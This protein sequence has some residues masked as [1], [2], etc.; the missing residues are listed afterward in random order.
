LP[1]RSGAGKI[2]A[3]E[4]S[5][6]RFALTLGLLLLSAA[7]VCGQTRGG[8]LRG[9]WAGTAYQ[10]DSNDTWAMSLTVKGRVYRVEYPSLDCG[11]R[12]RLLSLARGRAVFR[13]T[14]TRG[15]ERCAQSGRVV[16]ERLNARQLGYRY[17]HA[18][19]R[20]YVASAILN[21]RR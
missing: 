20:E 3:K 7:A 10:S 6:K 1:S 8:W 21:R 19:S 4:M 11:G 14:I 5:M 9:E 17:S 12:W 2:S 15:A 18:G 13:E 16:I